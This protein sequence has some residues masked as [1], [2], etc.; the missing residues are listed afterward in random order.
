VVNVIQDSFSLLHQETI[1]HLMNPTLE[2]IQK[3]L[4]G[5]WKFAADAREACKSNSW[6]EFQRVQQPPPLPLNLPA[7]L[8]YQRSLNFCAKTISTPSVQRMFLMPVWV[9]DNLDDIP[10]K[11]WTHDFAVKLGDQPIYAIDTSESFKRVEPLFHSFFE[12]QV[13]VWDVGLVVQS[14]Y[15]SHEIKMQ[16]RGW[17][18]SVMQSQV[19]E[20]EKILSEEK[21][22]ARPKPNSAV[23]PFQFNMTPAI[24]DLPD[25]LLQEMK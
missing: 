15:Y 12:L 20:V 8:S 16:Q 23:A 2:H 24:E 18:Y 25:V 22:N 1:P 10:T 5:D 21:K 14:R 9:T 7:F 17:I 13:K 11:K 19:I 3:L 6:R 4:D